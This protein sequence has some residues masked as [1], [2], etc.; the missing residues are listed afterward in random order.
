M[1]IVRV[2]ASFYFLV[3]RQKNG[4]REKHDQDQRL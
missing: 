1:F 3:L 2:T 4:K